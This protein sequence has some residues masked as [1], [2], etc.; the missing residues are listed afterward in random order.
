MSGPPF[1]LSDVRYVRRIVVGSDQPAAPRSQAEIQQAL[2]LL[3]RCLS[4]TPR[5]V[6]VGTEKGFVLLNIG[7]HQIVQQFVA[8]HVGFPRK[9]A[10]LD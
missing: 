6:I 4:D 1:Q 10:W 2:D 8:Y 5:G 3:N 9:P 7:E